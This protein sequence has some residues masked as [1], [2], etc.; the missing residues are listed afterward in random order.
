MKLIDGLNH[1][2]ILTADLDRFIG[3]YGDI[4]EMQ[5]VFGETTPTFRHAILKAGDGAW[6][7]PVE[8]QG[9][10]HATALPEMFTRGHIDHLALRA[11]S[12]AAFSEIRR[13]L[14]AVGACDGAVEDLG[15]MHSVWFSDPDG[16]RGAV[17][18][19]VDSA[20]GSFHEPRLLDGGL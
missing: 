13:R 1:V 17:C 6:L 14:T 12:S 8:L 4:F 16:M 5:V 10:A 15:A 2:A 11:P 20:L 9:N 19:V 18:L 3:F 7:H